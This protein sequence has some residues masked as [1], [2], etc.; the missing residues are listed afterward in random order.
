MSNPKCKVNKLR[1]K[2]SFFKVVP[3]RL[4]GAYIKAQFYYNS[5]KHLKY[6]FVSK[7]PF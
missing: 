3:G 6:W 5:S 4:K 1:L 2:V 7:L